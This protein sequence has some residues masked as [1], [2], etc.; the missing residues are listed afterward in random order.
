MEYPVKKKQK[1]KIGPRT[2]D[3]PRF[4]ERCH[5]VFRAPRQDARY[6]GEACRKYGSRYGS[7]TGLGGPKL[8]AD[9]RREKNASKAPAGKKAKK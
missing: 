3:I 2:K 1:K 7:N 4:C 6:C 5:V 9:P 8:L